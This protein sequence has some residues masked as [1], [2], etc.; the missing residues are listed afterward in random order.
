MTQPRILMCRPSYF[1]IEYE[2]N[3][4]MNVHS[5]AD[6]VLA[7]QQWEGLR[8]LLVDAGAAIEEVTPI[9]GLPDLVFTANA[10]LVFRERVIVSRF[11]HAQRQGEEPHLRN[12]FHRHGYTIEA[13]PDGTYFEGAGDALFC[14]ETLIAGYRIRS[15]ALGHQRIGARLGCRVLPVELVND[16]FYHLDTCFCPLS[17][18]TAIWYPAALDEYGRRAIAGAVEHLIEVD[19]EE[20]R[21][22]ACNAVVVGR[23]VIT[24]TGCDALAAQLASRGYIHQQTP[25]G[26]FTKAGGS[27]KC[28]TLRLDGEDAAVWR[29]STMPSS[30]AAEAPISETRSTT[31]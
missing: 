5:G 26:E 19:D 21:R 28:L 13:T 18:T 30:V 31:T 16:S 12:W 4:W 8:R 23:N 27:A 22:F 14:G 24:N 1:G 9:A 15:D 25:L 17:P 2:I 6:A 11:R 3:P 29:V 10:G 20:A 7:V